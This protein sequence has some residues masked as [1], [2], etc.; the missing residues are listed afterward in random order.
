MRAYLIRGSL[1]YYF[2]FAIRGSGI[3]FNS[4][5]FQ[6]DDVPESNQIAGKAYLVVLPKGKSLQWMNIKFYFTGLVYFVVLFIVRYYAVKL[7]F[8]TSTVQ[9]INLITTL[10]T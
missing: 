2:A 8:F 10:Y 5:Y 4:S 9:N 7:G 3:L 6:I 1:K